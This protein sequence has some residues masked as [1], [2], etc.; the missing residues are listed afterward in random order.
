MLRAFLCCVLALLASASEA[1][2][3]RGAAVTVG[4]A[5]IISFAFVPP[6]VTTGVTGYQIGIRSGG[7]AG[8]YPTIVSLQLSATS[9]MLSTAIIPAL[10]VGTYSAAVRTV[11]ATNSAWTSE[12]SFTISH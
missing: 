3:P 11:G 2:I 5:T 12:S 4:N 8:T 1:R 7:S 9:S 6:A 10:G